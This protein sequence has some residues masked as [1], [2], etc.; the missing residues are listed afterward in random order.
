MT[1]LPKAF[2][3]MIL[4]TS[5]A[6]LWGQWQQLGAGLVSARRV[7]SYTDPEAA[8]CFSE[9]F[10]QEEPRLKKV[11]SEWLTSNASLVNKARLK[12]LQEEVSDN[13]A[14]WQQMMSSHVDRGSKSGY[15]REPD[16]SL[17]EN[18][19]L[20]LR[21]IFG[22]TS[23]A[24][25]IFH[26]LTDGESNSNQISKARFLNQKAVYLELDR[27]S[28]A[29]I[30]VEKPVGRGRQFSLTDDFSGL[31]GPA[32]RRVSVS[33]FM[34]ASSFM[35]NKCYSVFEDDY[36]IMSEL[37]ENKR[38]IADMLRKAWNCNISLQ[39]ITA[40]SLFQSIVDYFCCI[41]QELLS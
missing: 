1:M 28:K 20:R 4:E 29:G 16:L 10:N 33:W 26:L 36:I 8:L 38:V 11:S 32:P 31:F 35:L 9:Q 14:T 41:S 23:R 25:A 12:R 13:S 19:L 30:L 2:R 15:M 27:L 21:M 3:E 40:E 24:E 17:Q 39:S 34:L 22:C 6:V 5:V 7:N 18:L 37:F